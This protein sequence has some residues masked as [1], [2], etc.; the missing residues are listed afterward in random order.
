MGNTTKA[1]EL[2]EPEE[3]GALELCRTCEAI[4]ADLE[5]RGGLADG[6]ECMVCYATNERERGKP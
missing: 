5:F 3:D 2:L 6:F 4:G 1:L